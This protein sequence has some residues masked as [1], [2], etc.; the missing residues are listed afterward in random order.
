MTIKSKIWVVI[1]ILFLALLVSPFLIVIL[2]DG[3]GP[4]TLD[5]DGYFVDG[6]GLSRNN[7][8]D[9]TLYS[10]YDIIIPTKV[11]EVGWDDSR[12][13]VKREVIVGD[14]YTG[15]V[16]WYVID[17]SSFLVTG[18]LKGEEFMSLYDELDLADIKM[19]KAGNLSKE[20]Y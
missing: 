12:I 3:F 17:R 19:H 5:Y 11:V 7:S 1:G 16:F 10:D 6:F 8:L 14:S 18:P 4:G 2:S 13:V 9:V 20:L 15:E